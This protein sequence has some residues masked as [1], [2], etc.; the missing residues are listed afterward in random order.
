M[1][2]YEEVYVPWDEGD[3]DFKQITSSEW[4]NDYKD[5]ASRYVIVQQISTEKYYQINESRTGSYY[6]DYYYDDPEI[7]EVTP[8]KKMVEQILWKIVKKED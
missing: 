4:E 6:S 8:E 7:F 1:N 2:L 5:Y 3:D